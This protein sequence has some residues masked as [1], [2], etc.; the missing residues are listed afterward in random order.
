VAALK[1]P[2]QP[3]RKV[4]KSPKAPAQPVACQEPENILEVLRQPEIQE[5]V[6][7]KPSG[8]EPLEIK[9]PEQ[10][11][12]SPRARRKRADRKTVVVKRTTL[13]TIKEEEVEQKRPL[14]TTVQE[15]NEE[16]VKSWLERAH[17]TDP[18]TFEQVT[19]QMI[20][21]WHAIKTLALSNEALNQ[22]RSAFLL[23]L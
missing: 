1:T 13:P 19:Q 20:A 22:V 16:Q 23:R 7:P 10:P 6:K 5:P 9:K 3:D 8:L 12:T 2:S 11:P 15:Q 18:T 14:E 21:E 17:S 4:E